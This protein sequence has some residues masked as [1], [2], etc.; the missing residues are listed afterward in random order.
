VICDLTFVKVIAYVCILVKVN[1][2]ITAVNA[3]GVVS[4]CC[5]RFL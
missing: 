2:C 4:S 3:L 1:I 5:Q